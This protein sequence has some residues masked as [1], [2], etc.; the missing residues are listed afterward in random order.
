MFHSSPNVSLRLEKASKTDI[1]SLLKHTMKTQQIFDRRLF[2]I[3]NLI[4][5]FLFGKQNFFT[6]FNSLLSFVWKAFICQENGIYCEVMSSSI[7]PEPAVSSK[8]FA[9]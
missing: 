6:H 7:K 5:L 4:K 2:S 3:K 1:L 8:C 9:V